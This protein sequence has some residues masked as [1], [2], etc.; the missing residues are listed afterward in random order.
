MGK[1]ISLWN[2]TRKKDLGN[3]VFLGDAEI[4]KKRIE[5]EKL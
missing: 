2:Q 1:I 3:W 4:N 5:L